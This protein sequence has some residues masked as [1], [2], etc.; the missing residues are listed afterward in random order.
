MEEKSE[1]KK[2]SLLEE[3]KKSILKKED[4]PVKD[5]GNMKDKDKLKNTEMLRSLNASKLLLNVVTANT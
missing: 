2:L 1:W 5:K 4:L 3:L